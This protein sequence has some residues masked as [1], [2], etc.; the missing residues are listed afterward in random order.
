MNLN[1]M[2]RNGLV[3]FTLHYGRVLNSR[4]V[5]LANPPWVCTCRCP[6]A[7]M[8]C[9]ISEPVQLSLLVFKCW[10]Y[11]ALPDKFSPLYAFNS[12]NNGVVL[13]STAN[14]ELESS[15]DDLVLTGASHFHCV[16]PVHS[17]IRDQH[18][19]P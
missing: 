13:F 15:M 14:P 11:F 1:G 10:K 16:A 19:L 7:C 6:I 9:K 8:G 2:E 17:K 18:M 12:V 5:F 4:D 3:V